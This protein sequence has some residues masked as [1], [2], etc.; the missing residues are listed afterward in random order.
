MRGSEWTVSPVSSTYP[1][2]SADNTTSYVPSGVFASNDRVYGGEDRV[3]DKL[4]KGEVPAEFE[5]F[6]LEDEF[7]EISMRGELGQ[8]SNFSRQ[9][10]E[11]K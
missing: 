10:W 8:K 5:P 7:L 2:N 6:N 4:D 9:E 3:E 11:N 1:L